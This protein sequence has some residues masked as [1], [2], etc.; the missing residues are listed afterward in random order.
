MI[1]VL[2]LRWQNAILLLQE[3]SH[4]RHALALELP[5]VLCLWMDISWIALLLHHVMQDVKLAI[6]LQLNAHHVHLPKYLTLQL[7]H[8]LL[9]L[10]L[11][12]RLIALAPV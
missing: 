8:A 3:R 11:E 12:S 10:T 9:V 1:V 4:V 6:L 2:L 7:T 5:P